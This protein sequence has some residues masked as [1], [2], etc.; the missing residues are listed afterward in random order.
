VRKLVLLT[1]VLL[2]PA[3]VNL[4]PA[5]A[6]VLDLTTAGSSGTINNARFY[7]FDEIPTGSGLID[8]FLRI[9]GKGIQQGYNTDGTT[10][11]QTMSSFTHS[12]QLSVVPTPYIDGIYYREFLLDIN[13]DGQRFLSVDDIKIYLDAAPNIS[14][15]PDNF[16]TP[17]YNLDAG[18]DNWITLD[19]VL[20]PGSGHGDMLALIPNDL[21]TGLES[22]YVYVYAKCGEHF[23]ADDG[24]EEFAY[25]TQGPLIPEPATI[26][27]LGL[28]ALVLLRKRRP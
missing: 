20:N 12:I 7:Q 6:A 26:M 13:Q 11:F 8:S 23:I 16:S 17:L 2:L 5:G 25:G 18:E 9:Q 22:Q 4:S 27:L 10:E 14:G 1:V 28:G 24:F 3:A 15:W 21:F 19:K